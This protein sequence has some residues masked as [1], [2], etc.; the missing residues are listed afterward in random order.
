MISPAS[1]ALAGM[2]E[3]DSTRETKVLDISASHGLW[4]LSF[5]KKNPKTQ[6]T[7][8]DWAPVL[9]LTRQ[10]AA[11]L[12]LGSRLHTIAGSAFEVEFGSDYDLVLVPNF[13]HHFSLKDCVRFLKKARASLRNDGRIAIVEFVPNEDRISPPEAAGFGLIMLAT[14]PEGDAYTLAEYEKMLAET[15]FQAPKAQALPPVSTVVTARAK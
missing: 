2:I 3:L 1:D 12:E 10:T 8:V 6:V 5:A 13:L 7:A 9:E 15:G 4:G 11:R 14:T